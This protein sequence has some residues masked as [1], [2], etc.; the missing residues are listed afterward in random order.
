MWANV[1]F[2]ARHDG[3]TNK[4]G[5]K[6]M[7]HWVSIFKTIGKCTYVA[8][9]FLSHKKTKRRRSWRKKETHKSY[10][11]KCIALE[12]FR[13][14]PCRYDK[15][16]IKYKTIFIIVW[17]WLAHAPQ[18]EIAHCQIESG[19]ETVLTPTLIISC[20]LLLFFLY[21]FCWPAEAQ[22]SAK[23]SVIAATTLLFPA[24]PWW[25][26][27]WWLKKR[28]GGEMGSGPHATLRWQHTV[29]VTPSEDCWKGVNRSQGSVDDTWVSMPPLCG[30]SLWALQ[31]DLLS[32]LSETCEAF[33]SLM[34]LLVTWPTCTY[35]IFTSWD[36]LPTLQTV[37]TAEF[38]K[39][40]V[41][42]IS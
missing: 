42:L 7:C 30:E 17:F 15:K 3:V 5:I 14:S 4:V 35:T 33:H 32:A 16:N 31:T 26:E 8:S 22:T 24:S 19:R 1:G 9:A 18:G 6:K 27:N 25:A 36:F 28:G 21:G 39:S 13:M 20:K 2:G 23:A 10:W 41:L 34:T 38:P 11:R 29:S 40:H 12:E 37:E